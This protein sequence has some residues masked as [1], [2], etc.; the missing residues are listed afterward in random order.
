MALNHLEN[1]NKIFTNKNNEIT[2]APDIR[3]QA[4]KPLQRMLNFAKQQKQM[5][6]GNA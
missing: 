6:P 2:I 1:L 5:A 3:T 4:M